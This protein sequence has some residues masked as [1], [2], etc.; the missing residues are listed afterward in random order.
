MVSDWVSRQVSSD[1]VSVRRLPT[2][3]AIIAATT[4][5]RQANVI[6]VRNS[7]AGQTAAASTIPGATM[8]AVAAAT[9]AGARPTAT[10]LSRDAH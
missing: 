2:T 3:T 5:A 7:V 6:R 4:T 9:P 8:F 1:L 10:K